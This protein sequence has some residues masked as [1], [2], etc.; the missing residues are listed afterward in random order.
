MPI[1]HCKGCLAAN[2]PEYCADCRKALFDKAKVS[3][4]LPF[5]K[6]ER[7]QLQVLASY[8]RRSRLEDIRLEYEV[9]QRGRELQLTN[10][11]GSHILKPAPTGSLTRLDQAPANEQLTMQLARIYNIHTLPSGLVNFPNGEFAYISRKIVTDPAGYSVYKYSLEEL[12]LETVGRS[13]MTIEEIGKFL[14]NFIGAYIPQVEKLFELAIFNSLFRVHGLA[15]SQMDL[16]ETRAGEYLLSPAYNLICTELH[17]E[18]AP[19]IL[20]H[21]GDEPFIRAGGYTY[22]D[23]LELGRRLG[24]RQKRCERILDRFLQN[25][26]VAEA[27]ISYSFLNP[28]SKRMYSQRRDWERY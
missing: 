24:M 2:V 3:S 1:L 19:D 6:P 21:V 23:F 27:L 25:K 5:K 9:L 10:E 20:Y 15:I 13:Y 17:E 18:R 12:F 28:E 16:L 22:P 7:N 8:N 26:L 14:R 4:I 11:N